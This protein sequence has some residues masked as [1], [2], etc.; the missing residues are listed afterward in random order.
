MAG[1]LLFLVSIV[2]LSNGGF[3]EDRQQERLE[4]TLDD[5][6]LFDK[7]QSQISFFTKTI[8]HL[9][10]EV[11][12]L[13]KADWSLQEDLLDSVPLGAI[14]PWI[15]KPTQDSLHQEDLPIGFA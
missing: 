9:N 10:E 14:L 13:K 5:H 2:A 11:D 7:L 8:S 3:A 6:S 15:N 1:L 4:T 12:S